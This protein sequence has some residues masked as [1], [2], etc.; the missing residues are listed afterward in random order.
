MPEIPSRVPPG[1]VRRDLRLEDLSAL[2]MALRA[3]DQ[4]SRLFGAVEEI[5]GK[6]IGHRLFTIMRVCPGGSEIERV[7]T[8][9]PAIYPVGGRKKKAETAWANHVLLDMKIFCATTPADVRAAFDDH[10][11]ILELGL[12]SILNIP[13]VF[14]QQ[15]V[16]TMNLCHDAGWYR[17][18]DEGTGHLLG[19]FLLPALCDAS[20]WLIRSAS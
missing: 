6:V 17:Q 12:G 15:C 16:G 19:T 11:T 18:E 3:G 14:N 2:A 8:S 13:V 1:S 4:P 20:A 7:Y 5:A 9:L 10:K